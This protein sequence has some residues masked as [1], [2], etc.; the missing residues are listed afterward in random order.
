M[1]KLY[2]V[3]S[4]S[5]ICSFTRMRG[6]L[7]LGAVK[8]EEVPEEVV[9]SVAETLRKSALLKI[10]EDGIFYVLLNHITVR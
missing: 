9:L 7:G 10:S 5:L 1:S 2:A 4:L 3:V 6:H 8:P